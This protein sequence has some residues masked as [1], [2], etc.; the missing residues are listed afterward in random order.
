MSDN[1]QKVIVKLAPLGDKAVGL[2]TWWTENKKAATLNWATI[3]I[4]VTVSVFLGLIVLV[5][6]GKPREDMAG[7]IAL[8]IVA[9][10]VLVGFVVEFFRIRKNKASCSLYDRC[11][12]L[13]ASI[14]GLRARGEKF[15][16]WRQ[17]VKLGLAEDDPDYVMR[18]Q[19]FMASAEGFLQS[20]IADFWKD[21]EIFELQEGFK[22]KYP[23]ANVAENKL[24]ELMANREPVAPKCRVAPPRVRLEYDQALLQLADDRSGEAELAAK[25]DALTISSR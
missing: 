25:I 4:S 18:H 12:D 13:M 16:I 10:G 2:S 3:M 15:A 11:L 23:D 17:Q 19:Q 8:A 9:V 1:N 5:A 20:V 24:S 7:N 14:V 21:V 6:M 22:K